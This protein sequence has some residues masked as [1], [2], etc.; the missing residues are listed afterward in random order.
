MYNEDEK[1]NWLRLGTALMSAFF[2][3][4][5]IICAIQIGG[6]L[7]KLAFT[8]IYVGQ[9]MSLVYIIKDANKEAHKFYDLFIIFYALSNAVFSLAYIKS[10][11]IGTTCMAM[12]T[13]ILFMMV[14]FKNIKEERTFNLAIIICL[15][16]IINVLFLSINGFEVISPFNYGLEFVEIGVYASPIAMSLVQIQMIRSKYIDKKTR[17]TD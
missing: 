12:S 5:D 15:L 1:I 13:F 9:T 11:L 2:I 3:V 7:F 4:L 8:L 14:F 6:I 10:H 16:Q 17:G